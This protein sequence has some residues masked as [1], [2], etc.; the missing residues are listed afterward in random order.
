MIKHFK[1]SKERLL[2][3]KSNPIWISIHTKICSIFS[4]ST[5]SNGNPKG[6]KRSDFEDFSKVATL[7][8]TGVHRTSLGLEQI[9]FIK[10][11][12][13]TGRILKRD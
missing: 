1:D 7:M 10:K 4:Y 5:L 13:N 9:R 3:L 11:G 6:V 8:S 12:M 2:Y